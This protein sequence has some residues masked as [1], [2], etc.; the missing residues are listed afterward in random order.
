MCVCV[1][2]V[3][4]FGFFVPPLAPSSCFLIGDEI[5]TPELGVP[6]RREDPCSDA[7]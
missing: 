4:V 7:A 1:F 6:P 3:D 2:V 5:A